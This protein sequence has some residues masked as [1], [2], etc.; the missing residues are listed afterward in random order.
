MLKRKAKTKSRS[1]SK[2]SSQ[3]LPKLK[4]KPQTG[5]GAKLKKQKKISNPKYSK[6]KDT[7][8]KTVKVSRNSKTTK[9][10]VKK[11]L[12][13]GDIDK[14]IFWLASYPK[15]GNTWFRAFLT[16]IQRNAEE[17]AD[18]NAMNKTPIASARGIF[19][20]YCGIYSAELT[21]AEIDAIRP[22]IYEAMT[23]NAFHNI[24]LKIHDA[25]HLTM[26][27][28]P[29][30]SLKATKGAIYLV[31]NPL[32]VAVSFA[33][34][35]SC[36]IPQMIKGMEESHYALARNWKQLPNQLRQ[37]LFTWK[38]HVNTWTTR[39]EFPVCMLRYEDMKN[40]SIKTF[41]RAARFLEIDCTKSEVKKALDK[42]KFER[43][44]EQE[45]EKGFR[46]KAPKSKAFFR[47]GKVGSWRE[48]LTAKQA[49]RII[50]FNRDMMIKLGYIDEQGEL[51]C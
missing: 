8:L 6:K 12:R 19:D 51:T 47:K 36:T 34:H 1:D 7:K 39:P 38:E 2:G 33:H 13:T 35:S 40:D 21:Q 32:D 46:E 45:Q 43:L 17:A 24:Y 15:S 20:E 41:H 26:N 16:N 25:Y 29:M 28:E 4:L 18:I 23:E 22:R 48:E 3:S 9:K 42:C 27:K 50:E 14:G 49:K 11:P 31:R 37:N 30:M 44:Q 5:S 10:K